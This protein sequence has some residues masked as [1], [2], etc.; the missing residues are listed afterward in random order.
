MRRTAASRLQAEY[1]RVHGITPETVH[2]AVRDVIEATHAVDRPEK[3][4]SMPLTV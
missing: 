3:E 4:R 2:K 1:N